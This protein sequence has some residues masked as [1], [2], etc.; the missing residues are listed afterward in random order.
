[1]VQERD[2]QSTANRRGHGTHRQHG[3]THRRELEGGK[4]LRKQMCR[5]GQVDTGCELPQAIKQA[6]EGSWG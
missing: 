5:Q 4:H 1:M 2:I 6:R 3:K